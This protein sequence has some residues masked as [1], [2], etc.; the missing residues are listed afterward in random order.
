MLFKGREFIRIG[1]YFLFDSDLSVICSYLKAAAPTSPVKRT[2]SISDRFRAPRTCT[3]AS[4]Q[5]DGQEI[6]LYWFRMTSKSEKQDAAEGEV[7]DFRQEG[8]PFV[9][10]AD[11]TRMPMVFMDATAAGNPIISPMTVSSG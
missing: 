2:A 11:E 8:G 6:N 10:A 1:F 9:V 3:R 4:P 5:F 7:E